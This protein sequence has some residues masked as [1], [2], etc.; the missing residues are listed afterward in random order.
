[1]TRE[2]NRSTLKQ[3]SFGLILAG[4]T[5]TVPGTTFAEEFSVSGT[6]DCGAASGDY[7]PIRDR[8]HLWT[9]DLSGTSEEVTIHTEWVR[10]QMIYALAFQ[11]D[12]FVFKAQAR[13]NGGLRLLSVEDHFTQGN[14][15]SKRD[16]RDENKSDRPLGNH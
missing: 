13:P 3:L 14:N 11:D 16:P 7:C 9:E 15:S 4:L 6:L 1:V 5:A 10:D 12:Y 8:M 2:L